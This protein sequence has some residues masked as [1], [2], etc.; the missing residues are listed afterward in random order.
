MRHAGPHPLTGLQPEPHP[1]PEPQPEPPQYT[2]HDL[3]AGRDLAAALGLEPLPLEGGLFRRTYT[4]PEATAIHFALIGDDFSALHRLTSDEVYFHHA[5]A[6]LRIL[7]I[8][9]DHAAHEVLI[10]SDVG[11]GQQPQFAVPAHWWQGSSVDGAWCLVSTVVTPGFDWSQFEL[12]DR[13]ALQ[14]LCPGAGSR[15]AALTRSDSHEQP[16]GL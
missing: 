3:Q 16:G 9:P 14:R 1:H 13:D 5:G 15:I 4:G 10:G 6:P 11:A 8:D 12:G 7:L 2:A